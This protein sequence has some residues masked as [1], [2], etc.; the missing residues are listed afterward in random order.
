MNQKLEELLYNYKDGVPVRFEA[1]S[2]ALLAAVAIAV[3]GVSAV[4]VKLVR[5]I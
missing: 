3:V 2:L 4:I 5:K 1:S